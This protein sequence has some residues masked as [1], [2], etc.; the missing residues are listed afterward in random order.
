MKII[1]AFL[2]FL[3]VTISVYYHKSIKSYL[4]SKIKIYKEKLNL[5]IKSSLTGIKSSAILK[6]EIAAILLTIV[7]VIITRQWLIF[8][9]S[10][11][12]LFFIP[13]I[14]E[15]YERKKY[16]RQYYLGLTGFLEAVISGLKAGLSIVK[17]LAQFAVMDKSPIGIEILQVLKKV[18]L[19]KSLQDALIELA[20]KIPLKENEI[21]ISAVNTA[22]ETGG[23]ITE[24]L[25]TILDTIRKRE[26]LGRE[27]KTL[28]SQGV[29][30]GII[31]GLLPV[32]MII[33]ISIMDP[34]YMAPLFN[35]TIGLTAL[36][37]AVL[38]EITGAIIIMKI[39]NVK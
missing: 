16:I 21:I 3:S 34:S 5:L 35:T 19:G 10:L 28:T 22:L 14:H 6:L 2:I 26:E 8:I 33:V 30:S 1:S 11:P 38:M 39:V 36:V 29:L 24:V 13:K 37:V 18:E 23:N 25:A 7:S 20:E 27:V 15:A 9:L 4:L 31:V 17:A 12:V 32:F